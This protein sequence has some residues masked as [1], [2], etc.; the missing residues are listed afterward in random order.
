MKKSDRRLL[1]SKVCNATFVMPF[2][3]Y[4]GKTLAQISDCDPRYV[5][6]LADKNVLKI[7][8]NF[9]DDVRRYDMEINTYSE[10]W[11]FKYS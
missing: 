7:E 8:A 10:Q 3:K 9:L 11:A 6:W 1:S 5:V 2:G 4:K